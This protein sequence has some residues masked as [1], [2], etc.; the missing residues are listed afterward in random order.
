MRHICLHSVYQDVSDS[1]VYIHGGR[2]VRVPMTL[3]LNIKN[4]ILPS[5]G[6]TIRREAMNEALLPL[7]VWIAVTSKRVR[8]LIS[9]EK[10]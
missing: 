9:I 4:I 7:V 3:T 5:L 6:R 8:S 2:F 10:G 1:A